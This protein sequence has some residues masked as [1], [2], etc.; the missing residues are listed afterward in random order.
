L[1]WFYGQTAAGRLLYAIKD[2]GIRSEDK[3]LKIVAGALII[4]TAKPQ[5]RGSDGA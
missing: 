3:Y 1:N 5:A 2:K 4:P